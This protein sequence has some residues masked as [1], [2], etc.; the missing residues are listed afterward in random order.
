MMATLILAITTSFHHRAKEKTEKKESKVDFVRKV[1]DSSPGRSKKESLKW[2]QKPCLV[3]PSLKSPPP[4][5]LIKG[6]RG[7]FRQ[8]R[9]RKENPG[10]GARLWPLTN[11]SLKTMDHVL[12]EQSQNFVKTQ[13]KDGRDLR[14]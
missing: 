5:P 14:I 4:P 11:D 6:G 7:D 1:R 3:K 9:D 2:G 12:F 10:C 13:A 8:D